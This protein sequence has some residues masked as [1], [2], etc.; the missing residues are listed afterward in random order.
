MM[1]RLLIELLCLPPQS[2]GFG[3]KTALL[4]FASLDKQL[5]GFP[6]VFD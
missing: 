6:Q 2:L 3:M 5:S 4:G 1:T